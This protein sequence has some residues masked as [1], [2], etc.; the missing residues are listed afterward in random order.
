MRYL[1]PP[2]EREFLLSIKNKTMNFKKYWL[3]WVFFRGHSRFAGQ[4]GKN[5]TNFIV[6]YH[7]H[8]LPYIRVFVC[9]FASNELSQSYWKVLTRINYNLLISKVT[10][11]QVSLPP[12]GY[13]NPYQK[14]EANLYYPNTLI[15]D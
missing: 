13:T 11:N 3:I 12:Q 6:L 2:P 9:C 7:F 14:I 5:E 4:Q 15:F 10:T 1:A 8:L